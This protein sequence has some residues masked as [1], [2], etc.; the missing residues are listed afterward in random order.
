M[1][2]YMNVY[3]YIVHTHDVGMMSG[4]LSKRPGG[5]WP[6]VHRDVQ[7]FLLPPVDT[8][9]LVDGIDVQFIHR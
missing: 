5:T 3:I 2:V 8:N 7:M 6:H 4:N 9:S 1:Y